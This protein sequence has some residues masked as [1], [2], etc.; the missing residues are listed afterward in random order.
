MTALTWVDLVRGRAEEIEREIERV[1]EAS[2]YLVR[3]KANQCKPESRRPGCPASRIGLPRGENWKMS[4]EREEFS[5][6][7]GVCVAG[8]TCVGVQLMRRTGK[9][10]DEMSGSGILSPPMKS[11]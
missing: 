10:T 9:R 3:D 2:T 8:W 7:D 6:S 5:Y 1:F 11:E 4:I